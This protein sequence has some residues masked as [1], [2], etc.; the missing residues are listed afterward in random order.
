VENESMN[1]ILSRFWD[2]I[3]YGKGTSC[4]V[5]TLLALSEYYDMVQ[6]WMI[7]IVTPFGGGMCH[8]H[9]SVCGVVSG[10]L[11]FLGLKFPVGDEALGQET[12][13]RLG[14]GLIEYVKREFG[15]DICDKMLDIDFDDEEQVKREKA[16]KYESICQPLM[17][18]VCGWVINEVEKLGK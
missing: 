5:T 16:D 1:K 2:G 4:S 7:D 18:N 14:A 15:D 10:A 3:A 9:R 17:K 11:M 12:S 13:A 6:P 8:S